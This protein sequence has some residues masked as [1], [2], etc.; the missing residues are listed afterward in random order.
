MCLIL[1][2]VRTG[3][4]CYVRQSHNN[5]YKQHIS[6]E[7]KAKLTNHSGYAS[8]SVILQRIGSAPDSSPSLV[9]QTPSQCYLFNCGESVD[10]ALLSLH[11]PMSKV[12]EIFLTQKNWSVMGGIMS[13]LQCATFHTGAPP[14]FHGSADLF[15]S[16]RRMSFL[17]S[18]GAAFTETIRPHIVNETGLYEDADVRI[19]KIPIAS[20]KEAEQGVFSYLCKLKA[21]R[22]DILTKRLDNSWDMHDKQ[23][24]MEDTSATLDGR[25]V[26]SASKARYSDREE[27]NFLSRC[28]YFLL[29]RFL[30]LQ[31]SD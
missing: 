14:N 17:S 10:R 15:K 12:T 22:G 7:L 8:G 25:T 13:M 2:R 21:L 23:Q 27:V 18:L 24:L 3:L 19:D 29:I 5:S 28:N 9:L 26:L 16:I 31:I 30:L 20:R 1:R 4:I 6:K 11:I